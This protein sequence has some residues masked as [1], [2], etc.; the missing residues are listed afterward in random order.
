MTDPPVPIIAHGTGWLLADK[1]SGLSVHNDPGKDLCSRLMDYLTGDCAYLCKVHLD[2]EFGLHPVHRL[3]KETSGVILLACH[4]DV[5]A[6]LSEAFAL[7]QVAKHYLAL[8]HG[9]EFKTGDNGLWTWPLTPKA[10]GRR[11]IQGKGRRVECTTAF[12]VIRRSRRYT[13]LSCRLPTGRTHQIRRHAALAGHPLLGDRRYGSQRACRY[14]EN[15][16]C[17]KRLA[18]HASRISLIPPG[19]DGIRHFESSRMPRQMERVFEAD[20]PS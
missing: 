12:R 18:L 8:V 15:T 9:T 4:R 13:L 14:L 5:F 16:F 19:A 11:N 2:P 6:S 1:P 10:A 7:N 3:D 17:F 20:L